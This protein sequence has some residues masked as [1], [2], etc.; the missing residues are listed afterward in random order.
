MLVLFTDIQC[1]SDTKDNDSS[2]KAP[3]RQS[4]PHPIRNH[5]MQLDDVTQNGTKQNQLLGRNDHQLR[6]STNSLNGNS[7]PG[8]PPK[9]VAQNKPNGI[10]VKSEQTLGL[11]RKQLMKQGS[12]DTKYKDNNSTGKSG[13][14]VNVNGLERK[15]PSDLSQVSKSH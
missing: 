8:R 2:L 12:S 5:L 11:E 13:Q 15:L 14:L 6:K 9:P 10:G 1:I 7:G 3:L 4:H